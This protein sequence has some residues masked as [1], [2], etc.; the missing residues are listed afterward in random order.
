MPDYYVAIKTFK[1]VT[2]LCDVTFRMRGVLPPLFLYTLIIWYLG[3]RNILPMFLG[4][5]V[6]EGLGN[7]E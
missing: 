4:D 2:Q 6:L 1:L 3:T 7:L 5:V